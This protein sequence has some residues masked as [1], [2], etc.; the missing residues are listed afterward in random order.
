MAEP[1]EAAPAEACQEFSGGS[2]LKLPEQVVLFL[3]LIGETFQGNMV[4]CYTRSPDGPEA[5]RCVRSHRA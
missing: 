3:P 2:F 1:G 4:S 5:E